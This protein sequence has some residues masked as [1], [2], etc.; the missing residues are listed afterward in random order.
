M[1]RNLLY[2][3]NILFKQEWPYKN[4]STLEMCPWVQQMLNN[5]DVNRLEMEVFMYRHKPL[6]ELNGNSPNGKV[7][8]HPRKIL[9]HRLKVCE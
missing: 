1:K 6:P 2:L 9:G 5:F 4:A 3:W 8:L 7:L